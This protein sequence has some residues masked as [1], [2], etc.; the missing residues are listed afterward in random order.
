MLRN[1]EKIHSNSSLIILSSTQL[2][3]QGPGEF[4]LRGVSLISRTAEECHRALFCAGQTDRTDQR[5]YHL[6]VFNGPQQDVFAA[7]I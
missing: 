2:L 3:A 5:R 4:A 7:K 1:D 6:G